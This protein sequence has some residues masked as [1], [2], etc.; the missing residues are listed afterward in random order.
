MLIDGKKIAD[1]VLEEIKHQITGYK[2]PPKL[3]AVLVGND[4]EL[5]SFLE[6]KGKVAK[7]IGIE[8][9]IEEFTEKISNT[10]LR[11]KIVALAKQSPVT[12]IIIELP[13]PAHLNTQY[14]L[15]A[16]PMEKDPDVLSQKAQGAFFV[17]RSSV[18]AP[19]AEAVKMICDEYRVEVRGRQC[20]V[21][22]YGL[23]VGKQVAHWLLSQGATVSV[24]NEHSP[25]PVS[26]ARH[27]DIIVSGV[28]KAG[29]VTADMVKEGAT[30][31]DFGWDTTGGAATGDVDYANVSAKAGLITPIPGGV[32]PLVVA[33]VLKNM[34]I[35]L[36]NSKS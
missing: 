34:L 33:A 8:Y 32:G 9:E 7:R 12:G 28:G 18:L 15:N 13:L 11:A 36:Q 30:V 29:L 24:I 6:L 10:E 4:P 1:A 19:S 5:K 3:V 26:Y 23:L 16:V 20:V 17:G 27:A 31:I 21:F 25:N 14:I 35:L 22:G 2:K